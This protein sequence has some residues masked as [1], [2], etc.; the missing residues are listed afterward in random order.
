MSEYGVIIRHM[1]P[2]KANTVKV[3]HS[4]CSHHNIGH[5]MLSG[6]RKPSSHIPAGLG[7]S[8]A[9]TRTSTRTVVDFHYVIFDR[10][11]DFHYDYYS[12]DFST[13]F[14]NRLIVSKKQCFASRTANRS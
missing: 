9:L 10:F 8:E 2:F 5:V 12:R 14:E 1:A 4:L 13:K 6:A 3:S 7:L 11:Y